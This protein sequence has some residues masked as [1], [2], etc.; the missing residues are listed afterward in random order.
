[1]LTWVFAVFNAVL[2]L[3]TNK[4]YSNKVEI[5]VLCGH[6]ALSLQQRQK[7][8]SKPNHLSAKTVGYRKN[9]TT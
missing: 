2:A 9:M 4:K 5:H 6:R 8:K 3:K 7:G 1:M